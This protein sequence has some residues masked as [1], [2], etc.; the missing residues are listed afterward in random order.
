VITAGGDW[1]EGARF[2]VPIL[3]PT[4]VIVCT[5]ATPWRKPILFIGSSLY[6]SFAVYFAFF[7]STS[8]PIWHYPDFAS[9]LPS[10]DQFSFFEVTNRIHYRDIPLAEACM[11]LVEKMN[12]QGIEPLIMSGQAGMAMYYLAQHSYQK[13]TFLDRF[14]LTTPDLISCEITRN[15]PKRVGGIRFHYPTLFEQFDSLEQL[16][17][18]QKPDIIF[19]LGREKHKRGILISSQGYS[20]VYEQQGMIEV[21]GCSACALVAGN[22]FI[23]VKDSLVSALKLER[24]NYRFK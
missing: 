11:G 23:A 18:F 3:S 10:S 5:Y 21:T 17:G 1:M 20:I 14:G 7:F 12:D 22:Q 2:W 4:M 15:F 24:T 6:I 8:I 9:K 16:C 19:D 13:F